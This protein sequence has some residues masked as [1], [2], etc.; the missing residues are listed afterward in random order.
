MNEE[1][2]GTERKKIKLEDAMKQM[3]ASKKADTSLSNKQGKHKQQMKK[4]TS[5]QTK[6]INNQRKRRGI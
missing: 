1:Q 3:L 4:M 6:K 5:Q 2:Q